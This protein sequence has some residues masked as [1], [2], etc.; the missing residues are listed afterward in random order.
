M[1]SRWD[2]IFKKQQNQILYCPQ[3]LDLENVAI[4]F[5][6]RIVA[7][8]Y[9]ESTTPDTKSFENVEDQHVKSSNH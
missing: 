8:V 3:I 4:V 9:V 7:L 6:E 5:E 2:K 1:N